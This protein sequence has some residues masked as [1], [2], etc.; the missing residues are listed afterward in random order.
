[1]NCAVHACPYRAEARREV[2]GRLVEVCSLHDIEIVWD[3]FESGQRP[4]AFVMHDRPLVLP[5][6]PLEENYG[7]FE[8]VGYSWEADWDWVGEPS[9]AVDARYDVLRAHGELN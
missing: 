7:P 2:R 4:G 8:V 1:V 3:I 6:G 9:P 5:V